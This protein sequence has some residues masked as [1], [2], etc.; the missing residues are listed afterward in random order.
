MEP[1]INIE[2]LSGITVEYIGESIEEV[3][4]FEALAESPWGKPLQG[5][6]IYCQKHKSSG[7][8]APSHSK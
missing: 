5:T 8:L 7:R 1:Q 4:A 6:G 3:V 2:L